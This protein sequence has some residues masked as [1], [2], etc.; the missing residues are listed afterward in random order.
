MRRTP[1]KRV[2]EKRRKIIPIEGNVKYQIYL[3]GNGL[4]EWCQKEPISDRGH[5]I[6]FR[7][8]GGSPTDVWN[9]IQLCRGCHDAAQAR[10]ISENTLRHFI[11]P[12]RVD[13]GW[14]NK[15]G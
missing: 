13:Q 3:M 15:E 12:I 6:K 5:E 8:H 11:I 2:S 1:I 10:E 4:C 14:E 7:S 9:I